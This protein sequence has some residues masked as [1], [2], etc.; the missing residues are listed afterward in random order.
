VVAGRLAR[1]W[2]AA[3][4]V[5]LVAGCAADGR[6]AGQDQPRAGAVAA[7]VPLP[8]AGNAQRYGLTDERE[9]RANGYHLPGGVAGI[10]SPALPRLSA[11]Q[12]SALT[13]SGP[14][15]PGD[16]PVPD[17]GCAGEAGRT[18]DAG[19]PRPRDPGLGQRLGLESF[20]RSKQDRRVRAAFGAWSACMRRAG[21]AYR[22][23]MRTNDDPAFRT[24]RPS[25][26]ELAVALADV[27]CKQSVGLVAVWASAEAAHQRRA[28][29]RH[30]S[31]LEVVRRLLAIRER[32][33]ARV[34]AAGPR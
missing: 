34:V 23:P 2:L 14:G 22:D 6:E 27:G 24:D 1:I 16:G 8:P 11:A 9:A 15:R 30:A 28:L 5:V 26:R 10:G 4:A 3:L 31:E 7:A 32:N 20:A 19:A 17:G 21:F 33:A 25:R 29:G 18:L 12:E 13:G